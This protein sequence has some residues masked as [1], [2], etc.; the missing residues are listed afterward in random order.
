MAWSWCGSLPAHC[1][2]TCVTRGSAGCG[3]VTEERRVSATT[4]GQGSLDNIRVCSTLHWVI[5]VLVNTDMFYSVCCVPQV[6]ERGS[7][8]AA[9]LRRRAHTTA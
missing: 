1:S 9:T 8:R 5:L 4:T 7:V 2:K 3:P 6:A